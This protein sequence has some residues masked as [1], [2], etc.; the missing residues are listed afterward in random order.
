MSSRSSTELWQ[1][2]QRVSVSGDVNRNRVTLAEEDKRT[3]RP[4]G[5]ATDRIASNPGFGP[6][7]S[8]KIS[9]T[10]SQLFRVE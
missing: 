10:I 5:P 8:N 3:H 9:T 7:S 1:T 2:V 6:M 4:I